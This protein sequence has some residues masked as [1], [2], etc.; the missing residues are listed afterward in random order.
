[1]TVAAYLA[2]GRPVAR[3][4]FYALAC[5]PQRSVVVE[6][7]AGAGKTWM[8]VSR[9]LRALLDGTQPHEIL[10]IT[11]TR[12]AAGEMRERLN[13]WLR[14]FGA[15][16]VSDATRVEALVARGVPAAAAA[17]LTPQLATLHERVLRAG[18]PVEIRTFHAW[19]SQLLRAA[20]L[21]LLNE[22]GLQPDMDLIEDLEDHRAEVFRRF[23]AALLAE[24]ALRADH[25]AL[26]A[27]R[28]RAQ[29][30]KWFEA[31]WAKRVEFELA[32]AAGVLEASVP[33][34]ALALDGAHPA[35]ALLGAAWEALLREL[36]LALGR[37]G[38][39]AQDAATGLVLALAQTEARARFDRAW[40]A[41]FT[42]GDTPRKQLGKVEA[43]VRV[44]EELDAI[45][46]QIRQLDAHLEHLRMVRLSR[47]LLLEFAAYKRERGLADMADLE[48]CG[49]A[50]LRDA[51]L[52]GWVQ[53]KLDARIRHVLIDEFQDTS[54]LQ[55][56]ALHAWLSAYAGAGGG[57]SGQRPP[58]LFIVGDPKQSIYRFRRAEPRVFEAAQQFVVEAL[59]G[60]RLSC[61]HTRRN[62]PEVLGAL[63]AVFEQAQQAG[64]FGG[65]RPHTTE[66]AADA[67]ASVMRLTRVSRPERAARAGTGEAPPAAW[68]DSLTT[69]RHEPEEVLRE[70]EE[71]QVA[72]AIRTLVAVEGLAPGDIFVLSRKRQSLRLVAQALC[73][74]RVPYAAVEDTTLMEAPEARDLVALLDALVSP[75]HRLSLAQALRSPLFGAGDDDLVALAQ[76]AAHGDWWRALLAD[77]PAASAALQRARTLLPGWREAA[78]TLPPHDLLDRIVHE[79]GLHERVAATVP[80]VQRAA[81]LD[82]IDAVLAQALTLDGAR[83]A[84]PYNFV[85]ALK[86]RAIKAAP[87]THADAVQLL[88]VHGAKGLEARVVF[89][90]DADP[91]PPPTETATL[92]IDWP[93]EAEQPRRCAFVYSEAA[94]PPSLAAVLEAER[95]ARRREELNGLYVAMSRAKQR[96][97]FSATEP[98]RR[99]PGASWWD[100]VEALAAAWPVPAAG[101]VLVEAPPPPATLK[102]L[103][104]GPRTSPPS[105]R[106]AAAPPRGPDT[107][108]TRL[109]QAVHRTLEWAAAAPDSPADWASLAQA[110]AD[111]FGAPAGVVAALAGTILRSPDCARFFAGP[112]LRWAGNEVPVGDAGELLRIDR[113]VQ[114]DEAGGPVWWVLDYKLQHAP[115][116]L[117]A[118][119][120]QLRR[121]RDAVRR[122]QPGDTVRCAFVTGAGAVVEVD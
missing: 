47:V 98:S 34:P 56:H 111:E 27:Q 84:T 48:R 89:V 51:T 11:F 3:E 32:D 114:L 52:A 66:L 88:T 82:A 70:R 60:L 95:Q 49:L 105:L 92:L 23:H 100:R 117:A 24:P 109:G 62:A 14:E 68:R 76:R 77:D 118:Y 106:P 54:P 120:E 6:A 4:A 44:Q 36:A 12:K 58:G 30:R 83:Y 97:V 73:A 69:P 10:A 107:D 39:K 28:G 37:G 41:L 43:L 74:Q 94:C 8:L 42:K 15:P 96:L 103:D 90:M 18:R 86:R 81:A 119:R 2:D 1:M 33:P 5:D 75:R 67:L 102:V 63:N 113:L 61:D 64:E 16:G 17:Q 91:E 71:A 21:E 121:Y 57:V 87:P 65:F 31:A 79:G 110:A 122:A 29:V 46:L 38:A 20:P 26:I 55:W 53:E 93:V 101:P 9:I 59:G 35:Q 13:D 108:A 25:A 104:A 72:Q 115:Q 22:L 19:F 40:A 7:C 85:R 50:L 99:A 80:P 78:Q 112:Q 45:A 116:Q